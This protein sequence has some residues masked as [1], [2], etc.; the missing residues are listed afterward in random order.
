MTPQRFA[1]LA[2]AYGG[3]LQRWPAAE[4]ADA[5]GLIAGDDGALD[6]VLQQ[7]RWLDSQLDH[8]LLPAA[9][10]PFTRQ[11]VASAQRVPSLWSRSF[12]WLFGASFVGVGV[13]GVLA[14]I[15]MMSVNL[16]LAAEHETLPSVLDG[17]DGDVVFTLDTTE[18]S[19]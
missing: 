3:D 10:A 4:Q 8:H 15:L 14:G 11:V 1:E 12:S 2:A 7:A 9:S 17:G 13:A 19:P 18:E 6:T 16:P 5:R